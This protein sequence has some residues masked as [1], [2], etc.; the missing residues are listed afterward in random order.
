MIDVEAALLVFSTFVLG[1]WLG[2]KRI[3][4][5]NQSLVNAETELGQ[6][7]NQMIQQ[8]SDPLRFIGGGAKVSRQ[9]TITRN[10][11]KCRI[12]FEAQEERQ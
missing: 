6:V 3:N 12:T 9:V 7:F 8:T 2:V 1:F 11:A 5:F 10:G 4:R